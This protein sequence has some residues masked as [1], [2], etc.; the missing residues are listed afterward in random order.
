MSNQDT[1]RP[2]VAVIILNWNG[3]KLLREYLPEVIATTDPAIGRVIVADNGS[4]D[5]SRELLLNEFPEVECIFFDENHGFAEGYNKA[6]ALTDYKYTVLLNSDV[7]TSDGW[8]NALYDFMEA[9]PD[10]GACQPKMLSRREPERFEY[11]GAAGGYIDCN[12]YPF[13][14]GRIFDCCELDQGQYDTD[15]EIFWA[16]GACL[17]V[18]TDLY[19]RCGGL[20]ARFFA[21]MEEIDLCWRILLQG[22]RIMAVS[23]AKVYHLGGGSLPDSNPRKTYLNFRNNL[24]MLH[25]N[26]PDSS[27]RAKLFRRRLLDTLAWAKYVAAFKFKFAAAIVKAHR[28]FARMRKDYTTHPDVDLLAARRD[29]H[30]NILTSFFLRGKKRFS[31]LTMATILCLLPFASNAAVDTVSDLAKALINFGPYAA[32]VDYESLMPGADEPTTTKL[33]LNSAYSAND[34]IYHADYLINYLDAPEQSFAAYFSGN[35]YT[36]TNERLE[37]RHMADNDGNSV[38]LPRFADLLPQ[39]LG[40]QLAEM[41]AD[42][43]YT[44]DYQRNTTSNNRQ[45]ILVNVNRGFQ[46]IVGQ[47]FTFIF[48]EDLKPLSF[49]RISNPGEPTEFSAKAVYSYSDSI[50]PLVPHSESELAAIYPEAFQKWRVRDFSLD[51]LIGRR[52]PAFSC[53]T[54]SG[55]RFSF[56]PAKGF[57]RPTTIAILDAE[58]DDATATINRLRSLGLEALIIAFV[59]N[60]ADIVTDI[61]GSPKPGEQILISARG[62]AR[63]CGATALPLILTCSTDA[64]VTD[65]HF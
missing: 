9:N 34:S 11:A 32:S 51:N 49:E 40:Q 47:R 2:P 4:T 37:E 18:R 21:H 15:A 28:D 23:S 64:T 48:D 38:M 10:V 26:L 56:K 39:L 5:S 17:M 20:D 45:T 65:I 16:S 42:S 13:C 43:T 8:L 19:L 14:R 44:I 25:K 60:N 22:Y 6:I 59:N 3:E 54:L 50:T 53:R 55:D 61:V 33:R 52:L 58:A 24:L 7:A 63:D 57:D 31:Q 30:V 35:Y 12:G 46:G 27:R 1:K 62:L 29:T 41:T 36:L